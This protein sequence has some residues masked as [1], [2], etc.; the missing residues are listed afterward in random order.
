ML[1]TMLS[2]NNGNDSPTTQL[3]STQRMCEQQEQGHSHSLFHCAFLIH[4]LH[5]QNMG[6]CDS[7]GQAELAPEGFL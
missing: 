4:F 3:N 5:L 6:D 2:R 1:N 7:P